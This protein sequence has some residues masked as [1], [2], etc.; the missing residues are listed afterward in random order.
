M[1]RK[2]IF[3][4]RG[5]F[6]AWNRV[7]KTEYLSTARIVRRR[8][9]PPGCLCMLRRMRTERFTPIARGAKRIKR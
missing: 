5:V 6:E 4:Q 3:M 1:H 2:C 7:I 8:N 9:C